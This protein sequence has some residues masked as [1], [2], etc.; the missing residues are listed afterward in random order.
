MKQYM[1][2]ISNG[3]S[4][5]RNIATNTQTDIMK[6]MGLNEKVFIKYQSQLGMFM[7]ELMMR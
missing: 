1:D 2:I 7:Q 5:V 6:E 4:E 3:M